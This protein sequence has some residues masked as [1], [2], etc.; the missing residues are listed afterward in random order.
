MGKIKEEI[1][2]Q[3]T[4]FEHIQSGEILTW[5]NLSKKPFQKI[6]LTI[7]RKVSDG[8]LIEYANSEVRRLP[9]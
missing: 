7:Y 4:R 8:T 2:N 5:V 9:D 1:I 3:F 6:P